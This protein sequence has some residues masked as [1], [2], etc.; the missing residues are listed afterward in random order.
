MS[1]DV[2]IS[3]VV[4]K[5]YKAFSYFSLSIHQMNILIGPNNCG[6]STIIGAFRILDIAMKRARYK[7]A[8]YLIDGIY[9]HELSSEIIPVSLENIHTNYS[10]EDT[11]VTFH[12]NNKN[13]MTLLFPQNGGCIFTADS[14]NFGRIRNPAKFKSEFPI[15]IVVVPVMGPVEH[16]EDEK[17]LDTIKKGLTTHRA[18]RHFRNY[19]MKFPE[20]FENF[21]NLVSNSWKGVTIER[22]YK[23]DPFDTKL[24]MFCSE[25]RI[26]RELYWSGFGFQI[27]CQLLTHISRA[28]DKDI[29]II[30]EP[31]IYL[32]PEVQRQLINVLR[33]LEMDILIATHSTEILGEADASEVLLVDKV[34]RSAKRLRDIEGIQSA[35]DRIGSIQNITLSQLARNR[36]ILFTEG[37]HDYKIL[38]RFAKKL[39]FDLLHKGQDITSVE[40]KGFSNW[41][42]IKSFAWGFRTTFNEP[43][44]VA[45]IFDRDFWC[46]EEIEM[47]ER[48]LSEDIN[49]A[50]IHRRK[51]IENYLLEPLVLQRLIEKLLLEKEKRTGETFEDVISVLELLKE[52]TEPFKTNLLGQYLAKRVNYFK[53]ITHQDDATLHQETI[54]IFETKWNNINMRVE[55]IK[56][57]DILRLLRE[58]IQALYGITLTD[59]RIIDEFKIEELTNEMKSLIQKLEQFRISQ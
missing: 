36:R 12:L 34:N 21:A 58:K 54:D 37:K 27:W 39:G 11:S 31:E 24:V 9:G 42:K 43:L 19:W 15:E 8:E 1:K 46:D 3:Q 2:K 14:E 52:I 35:I 59:Y 20:D 40:S 16:E 29:L 30:D 26:P 13:K 57:S 10:E 32:H 6:K 56:G 47:I 48:N 18:S 55:I 25:D 53:D 33:D 4:F 41:E 49:F 51:E 17:T 44:R 38:R 28:K 5:N 45:A 22:P 23:V 7:S 50:Y